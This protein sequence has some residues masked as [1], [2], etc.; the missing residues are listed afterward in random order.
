LTVTVRRAGSKVRKVLGFPE[1]SRVKTALVGL[2]K[3]ELRVT[4]PSTKR[5]VDQ[6]IPACASTSPTRS[7]V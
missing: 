1:S 3:E 5:S 2:S 7:K 4:T 6:G